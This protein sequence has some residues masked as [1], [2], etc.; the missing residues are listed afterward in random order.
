MKNILRIDSSLFPE[1]SVSGQL[2]EEV[3]ERLQ[4]EYGELNIVHRN[5][6]EQAIPHLDKEW[7]EALNSSPEGRSEAQQA[8]M[9]FSNQLI[10]EL[11][12]AD[13]IILGVP[14]YNFGVS[15]AIKAWFDHVAR[16]GVTFRYTSNGP[17]G[18]LKNKQA[19]AI[20]TRGG[21][22]KDKPS[23]TQ[24][25]FVK[26]FL[27][28]IGISDVKTVYAEGMNMNETVREKGL[29]E[30]RDAIQQITVAAA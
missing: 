23:D 24:I 13:I 16:A 20:S 9:D 11:Q 29:A 19:I 10:H 21:L 27:A 3:I 4:G 17:E 28:F 18:L 26:N 2:A 12:K 8:K 1:E 14:M 25:P 22:H 5:L 6:G 7:L 30:A 15:S